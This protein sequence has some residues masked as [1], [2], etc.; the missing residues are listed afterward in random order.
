MCRR[1][2]FTSPCSSPLSFPTPKP[3][4]RSFCRSPASSMRFL[5]YA[6]PA[7]L[8][9][10]SVPAWNY[11][12]QRCLTK[13]A[14]NCKYPVSQTVTCFCRREVKHLFINCFTLF[15]FARSLL[16]D[17]QFDGQTFLRQTPSFTDTAYLLTDMAR[18][19]CCAHGYK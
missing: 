12:G 10:R 16:A 15:N 3:C 19:C 18:F 1:F 6:L 14:F 13:S 17:F 11:P 7:I 9:A 5:Q 4:L 2:R 8:R